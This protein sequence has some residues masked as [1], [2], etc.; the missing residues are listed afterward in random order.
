MVARNTVTLRFLGDAS[1][2][3]TTLGR[4]DARLGALGKVATRVGIGMGVAALSGVTASVAA[5]ASF[6]DAMNQSLAIMG[7]VTDAQRG[8]MTDAAKQIGETTRLSATEAAESFFFLASAGL[9]AEQ[10]MAALP[11]VAKFAQAGMFDMATATD[12][13]T[14][15]QVALGMGSK[16]PIENL[17]NLTHVTDVLV[18][19]NTMA[20]ASVEQF[21]TA[22]TT[23]A[24]AA[25]KI[26]NKD[27]EEG[28]AVLAVFAN[29]GLKG[30]EAGTSLDIVM[31]DLNT[32]AVE[33][34]DAFAQAG[35]AVH[36]ADGEMRNMAD[37]VA[38]LE[39]AFGGL[40]IEDMTEQMTKLG[41]S[42]RNIKKLVLLMGSSEEIREI[43]EG[44]RGVGGVTDEVANNQLKSFNAQM[45]LLKGKLENVA[46]AVGEKVAPK[47]IA[48][49]QRMSDWWDD[50]AEGIEAGVQQALGAISRWWDTTGSRVLGAVADGLL[51]IGEKAIEGFGM[52]KGWWD[53]NGEAIMN[54][55]EGALVTALEGISGWFEAHG[56]SIVEIL[57]KFGEFAMTAFNGMSDWWDE[58]GDDV[59]GGIEALGDALGIATDETAEFEGQNIAA[60]IAVEAFRTSVDSTA[61]LLDILSEVLVIVYEG[62]VGIERVIMG[63]LEPA[64]AILFTAAEIVVD[65]MWELGTA[66]GEAMLIA[67]EWSEG[68][69]DEMTAVRQF[70]IDV[71]N[72]IG[73]MFSNEGFSDAF[74][75]LK[76][77]FAGV[78][79]TII[80]MWNGIGFP[81]FTVDVGGF[82][83]SFG[84]FEVPQLDRIQS[85]A[86]GGVTGVNDPFMAIVGDNKTSREIITPEA[87]MRDIVRSES[88]GAGNAIGEVNINMGG[89][90]SAKEI[91]DE[92]QWQWRGAM[93]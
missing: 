68:I 41:F 18:G 61:T 83:K 85:Y 56:D 84:G 73:D 11:Q 70:I 60:E 71:W 23:S 48:A 16:D 22:L 33:N 6:D 43:E 27:I 47:I 12:L 38:D 67:E 44:L 53:E 86:K 8:E 20:N 87:L 93:A 55:I 88:G 28:A 89:S 75:G 34:K 62:L 24:G 5:F 35:V 19:A 4:V 82:K 59:L 74:N 14:D 91:V 15:A 26:Y 57:S 50:N 10:S 46:I 17:K 66:L 72:E 42:Q 51:W 65:I 37:I 52:L 3:N 2:L 92:I 69:K 63:V 54:A 45:D 13:A 21:S 1:A 76:R 31:R 7:N 9:D 49:F 39:G 77:V 80:D 64:L 78:V 81:G 32:K 29:Q 79:N 30:A 90:V 36:D 40:P 25:L 58:D